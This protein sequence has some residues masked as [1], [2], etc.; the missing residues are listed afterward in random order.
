MSEQPVNRKLTAVFYADIAGYSRL[1]RQ[2]EVGTHQ[3]VMTVL[4]YASETITSGNGTVLRYA[5]DAILAEFQSIVAATQTAVSIQKELT[6]RNLEKSANDKIQ[7]RIGINLGEVMQDRGEI[8]GDGV[9]LAARL[10]A[11]AQPGGVCISSFVFEQIA[12]KVTIEFLDGGEQSFKNIDKPIRVYHWHPEGIIPNNTI[13]PSA[14]TLPD[15]PSIA[16]LPFGNL[17]SDPEQDHFANGLTEDLITDLSKVSGLF[18]VGRSSTLTYRDKSIDNLT[19]A[20]E[21][22]VRY[23][24]EGSVRKA[25]NRVR[26]NVQLIDTQSNNSMW[27]DRYDGSLDDV[28]EL[29]DDVGVKVVTALSVQLTQHESRRP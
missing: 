18:V 16:V 2:D 23:L 10:E 7:I 9:N 5:G 20:A 15:K 22:G 11:A 4:D 26:I 25:G 17:S 29:Q 27:A 19:V 3:Q 6:T 12:S 28:F 13:K 1:T 14:P 24:L 21:L 8:F